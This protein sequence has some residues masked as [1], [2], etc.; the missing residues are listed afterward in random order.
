MKC[1][2]D[3]EVASQCITD[4]YHD[5]G[6]DAIYNDTAQKILFLIQSKW[7]ANGN[8]SITQEESNTFVEGV[9]RCLNFDFNGCNTKII[10][11]NTRYYKSAL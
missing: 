1:G 5:M 7:R 10:S 3:Y 8:G 9:T 4:G 2:L 11:K 6:I